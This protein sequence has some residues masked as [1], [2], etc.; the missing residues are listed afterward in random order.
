MVCPSAR[1]RPAAGEIDSKGV[2]W[3]SL[4]RAVIARQLRSA[5]NVK[6]TLNG[7]DGNRQSLSGRLAVL[8]NI[9]DQVSRALG[10]N[11][12]RESNHY[13]TW[14]DQHNTLGLGN[15]DADFNRKSQ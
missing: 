6:G 11:S 9:R 2:V 4:G 8:P 1:L 14:V 5:Q 12:G 13:Y 7:P 15:D 10:E 3:V